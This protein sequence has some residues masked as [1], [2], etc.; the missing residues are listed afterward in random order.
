MARKL[1]PIVMLRND[2]NMRT[3]VGKNVDAAEEIHVAA[4]MNVIPSTK[5]IMLAV[6]KLTRAIVDG[7][8]ASAS[9]HFARTL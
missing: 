2:E 4:A 7:V 3:S 8:Y 6:T 9:C 5:T 1:P